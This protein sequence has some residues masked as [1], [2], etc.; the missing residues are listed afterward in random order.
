MKIPAVRE[1]TTSLLSIKFQKKNKKQK[2]KQK[3]KTK[4]NKTKITP[5]LAFHEYIR[6]QQLGNLW[7]LRL[8]LDFLIKIHTTYNKQF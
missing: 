8:Q 3:T 2:Q 7:H 4:Q 5:P 1:F 6:I